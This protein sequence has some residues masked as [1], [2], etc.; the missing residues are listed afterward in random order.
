MRPLR[1]PA[2]GDYTSGMNLS[3]LG[4]YTIG[5]RL[6]RGGMGAVYEA[7]EDATGQTVALKTLVAHLGDDPGLRRRFAAEIEV[8][9]TLRHPGIVQLLAFGEQDGHPYFAMELVRGKS[10]EQMLRAGRRFSW[11]ETVDVALEIT[12]ALKSAHDHG[13][14]HR[15]LKPANLLFADDPGGN[16]TVKLADFG[17]AR[18]FGDTG[19]TQAG[20]I[21][22]TAEYMAPEQAAGRSVDHRADL[23]ALGLVMYAMLTGRPPFQGRQMTEVLQRQQREPAPRVSTVVAEVPA[24]LDRIIDRLLAKDPDQRP[25]SALAVGRLLAPLAVSADPATTCDAAVPDTATGQP[26]D[27]CGPDQ[28]TVLRGGN[29]READVDLLAATREFTQGDEA[30]AM[31]VA[32]TNRNVPPNAVTS[33][34]PPGTDLA[35]RVTEPDP[36]TRRP[37][38]TNGNRFTTLEEL[39]RSSAAE[40][41]SRRSRE[42]RWQALGVAGILAALLL[43]GFFLARPP[44]AEQ[45]QARIAAIAADPDA[46]LR[47]ARPLIEQF[48][49]RYGADP[50]AAT[51]RDLQRTLDIDALD[52]RS[53]RR[54]RDDDGMT[55]IEREYRAAMAREAESPLACLAALQAIVALHGGDAAAAPVLS[56]DGPDL[57][58]A[59]VRR[60]IDR[61]GPPADR[62]RAEDVARAVATLAEAADLTTAAQDAGDDADRTRLLARRRTLLE[63]LIELYGNRPH[64][65]DA[66]AEARRLLESP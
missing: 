58:L 3:R 43:G 2:R 13:V 32:A 31:V 19:Q 27:H 64:A 60:Q 5:N 51:I 35:R 1:P 47:D 59:L 57:W 12:R 55:A 34:L 56:A 48:L 10:L 49:A 23:Y 36:G 7:V 24:E 4:P 14:V 38:A 30:A 46:D 33:P 53:R 6:G 54:S 40:A 17:I 50:H 11:R 15:D 16:A 29:P 52:R 28:A 21:V 18:L 65:A 44:S 66:V 8:L 9:Q 41:L 22:G 39:H 62:E 26:T 25:Q 45:L 63:G 20:T 61:L 42:R 37:P